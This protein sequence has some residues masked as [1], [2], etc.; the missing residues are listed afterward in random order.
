MPGGTGEARGVGVVPI[1]L[2]PK[3]TCLLSRVPFYLTF[4]T[5]N[6]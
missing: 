1:G 3:K 6:P 5:L 4:A 2:D